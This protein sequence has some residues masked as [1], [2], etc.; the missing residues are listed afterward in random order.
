MTEYT[1]K[2]LRKAFMSLYDATNATGGEW[3]FDSLQEFNIEFDDGLLKG[4]HTFA[5]PANGLRWLNQMLLTY[6][7]LA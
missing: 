3:G 7:E 4:K 5:T 2:N 6:K 1:A